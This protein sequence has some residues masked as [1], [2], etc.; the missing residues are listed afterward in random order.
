M[1]G[2]GGS[3]ARRKARAKKVEKAPAKAS[4]APRRRSATPEPAS[5]RSARAV[6]TERAA[7]S[8]PSARLELR[9]VQPILPQL[10]DS[11]DE[12]VLVVNH[13]RRV[14]AAN[15]RYL[16]V[17][18]LDGA[19]CSEDQCPDRR[20]GGGGEEGVGCG[21][22]DVI[23]S[24]MPTRRLR[25]VPDA[26]GIKRRWE[27]TMSPVIGP[28]GEVSHVVE[29]WRDVSERTRLESQLSHSERLASLGIL[30]A[31]VAH[32]INN[33]LASVLVAVESVQRRLVAGSEVEGPS[34]PDPEIIEL[35][36]VMERETRRCREISDKLTLLAQPYTGPSA[37]VDLNQAV[38]DTLTLLRYAMKRQGV[39]AMEEFDA[40]LPAI[41]A[42]ESGMRSVCMNLMLNAVQAMP[43]GGTL[44]VRT[45]GVGNHV[46][47]EVSDTGTGIA[48]EN[49]DR[50]WDPFFTTK[51][52]GSGT[53]LGL[54]ITQRIVSR[55]G[56]HIGAENRPEGGARFTVDLPVTGPGG[57]GV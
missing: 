55:H 6:L 35:L 56:G 26:K 54:S 48:P 14:V 42:R 24:R 23:D 3:P 8:P 25:L 38:R 50:I 5:P 39:E 16:E 57:D 28:T 27:G 33:P 37:W 15:R 36:E 51:P 4:A 1:S 11:L 7:E 34:A 30:A 21:A 19:V 46:L 29:V 40:A 22:C 13:E 43:T 12:A 47:L 18:G 9:Q 17:F 44:E 31:G 41:W 2:S 53:G 20:L 10:I 49:L 32:E 52:P 45:K